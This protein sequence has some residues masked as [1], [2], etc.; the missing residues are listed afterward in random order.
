MG[1]SED[2]FAGS[3]DDPGAGV[4][5]PVAQG[6][7][8]GGGEVAVKEHLVQHRMSHA[9]ATAV[10]Q[11]VSITNKEEGHLFR[12]VALAR[13]TGIVSPVDEVSA[14]SPGYPRRTTSFGSSVPHTA[15]TSALRRSRTT[16]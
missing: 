14:S 1:Y 3:F 12:P 4:Q 9:M 8:F 10:T 15:R 6:L 7:W 5:P 13:R 11:A 2:G 16:R